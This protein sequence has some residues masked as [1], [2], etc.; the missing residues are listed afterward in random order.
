MLTAF[1]LL[2]E[3]FENR[4]DSEHVQA[5]V[6]LGLTGLFVVYLGLVDYFEAASTAALN[7]A[8]IAVLMEVLVGLALIIAIALYPKS[9]Q[10]RR[11]IGMIAD[12]SVIGALMYLLGEIGAPLYIV[13]LWVTVGNGLRYGE[14]YL[15]A[16]VGLVSMTFAA[17]IANTGYWQGNRVLAVGLLLGLPAIPLYLASL[18]RALVRATEEAKRASQAKSRFLAN[19]SHELRT[20]L[21]GIVGM[22]ELLITTRLTPEQRE[23]AEV[24]Q[25]SARTL[26]TLVDDVLDISSIEA[27]KL[28]RNEAEFRL[29]DL[30]GG[31]RMLL[32]PGATA[33][34]L[35]F[36]FKLDPGLPPV[37][38]GDSGHL[39]QI[40]VNLVSNAIKFTEHGRVSIDATSVTPLQ[41]EDLRL[42]IVVA[43]TGIGIPRDK[44]GTIFEAFEQADGSHRRR[45]G[46]TGL[47]TTIARA[48]VDLLGGRI[49]VESEPDVGS[50]FTVEVPLGIATE[51]SAGLQ[52]AQST[53]NIIAFDD[54]FVR[55]KARVRALRI[56][57]A[58]DQPANLM[59]LKR[60]LERAGHT[61]R[62]VASGEDVLMALESEQYDAVIIDLHMPKLSGL[63]VLKQARFM[64]AGRRRTPFIVLTA[65]ATPQMVVECER[66]GAF[67]FLS[68]P[69]SV[70]LLLE[71][72]AQVAPSK[73]A[74]DVIAPPPPPSGVIIAQSTLDEL[75]E[76]GLG[77]K[78]IDNFVDECLQDSARCISE[79]ETAGHGAAWDLFRDQCHALKGVASNMGAIK[80]AVEASDTMRMANWQLSE[81]W[82]GN[83]DRLRQ[84]LDYARAEHGRLRLAAKK[85]RDPEPG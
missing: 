31:I 16:A 36:D 18:L 52:L 65:D 46:G 53:P 12:Y 44:L 32:L 79:L 75:R 5:L 33:K 59:M 13:L 85:K 48:L 30:L 24:I 21:N 69:I 70:P 19:M 41:R 80:L 54:P 22:A 58:D 62:S 8:A 49:S 11:W 71:K 35:Q 57:V 83:L 20:P 2:R 43:D 84:L 82:R 27:G 73:G 26:Q 67:A 17:V 4:P 37:L 29:P 42:R 81:K 68:K 78:F 23:S 10:L 51:V 56:L 47:G 77:E 63:D 34:G 39:R 50:T 7:W 76:M 55:H 28:R 9:S 1:K 6:R 66:A 64:E 60:L 72:L 25:T 38:I 3:R 74:P 40:L 61:P 14:R 45:Y 15:Y